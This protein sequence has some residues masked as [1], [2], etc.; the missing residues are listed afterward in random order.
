MNIN[1]SIWKIQKY[2]FLKIHIAHFW[3][4]KRNIVM[5]VDV[6]VFI[7]PMMQ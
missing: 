6:D 4:F 3:K 5:F 7:N 1:Y 2:F